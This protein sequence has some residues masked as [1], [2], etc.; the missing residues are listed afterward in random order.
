MLVVEKCKEKKE[1][2]HL[3]FAQIAERSGIPLSTVNAFFS[4]SVQNPSYLTVGAICKVLNTSLDSIIGIEDDEMSEDEINRVRE[5]SRKNEEALS[6][7][8]QEHAQNILLHEVT[9][10]NNNETIRRQDLRMEMLSDRVEYQ[11]KAIFWLRLFIGFVA[12]YAAL[13]TAAI[14]IMLPGIM[15][16]I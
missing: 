10:E 1:K 13:V 9:I 14:V 2:L 8:I 15:K 12:F 3:T 16:L 6:R 4:G 7:T 5:E 11:K